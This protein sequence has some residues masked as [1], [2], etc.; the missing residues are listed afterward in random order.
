MIRVV[1]RAFVD[2]AEISVQDS[3]TGI[4]EDI[5][6]KI[7]DPFFTT[8][9]VGK[10]TGQGLAISYS[11]IVKQHGGEIFVKSEMGKGT[12]FTIKLPFEQTQ[13]A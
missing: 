5:R 12:T 4:P 11:I 7:F 8:K 3:G 13:L 2:H 6:A 9:P 1:T 10:G